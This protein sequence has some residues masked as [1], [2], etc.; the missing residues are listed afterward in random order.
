[1]DFLNKKYQQILHRLQTTQ[2]DTFTFPEFL[3]SELMSH[4]TTKDIQQL[5]RHRHQEFV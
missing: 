4:Q 2:Q 3:Q 5:V 1:M